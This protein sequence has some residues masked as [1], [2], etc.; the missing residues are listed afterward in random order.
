MKKILYNTAWMLCVVAVVSCKNETQ[1]AAVNNTQPLEIS[2]IKQGELQLVQNDSVI[3]N[4]DIEIADTDSKRQI[5]LMNRSSMA[6][7]Q[8]M[9]FEF[10]RLNDTGFWM[11]DTRI[12]LD[13]MFIAEDSTV[14]NVQ[15]NA[16]PHD[17]N[18]YA[19]DAPYRYVLEVN[20]GKSDEWGVVEGETKLNWSRTQ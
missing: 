2:F 15:R 3:K 19:A 16:R 1:P 12:A 20:G 11:K 5:G 4:L 18:N 7:N 14:I 17:K 6:E 8:G 9:L 13:I 10:D